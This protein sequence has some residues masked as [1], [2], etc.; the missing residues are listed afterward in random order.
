MNELRIKLTSRND[1]EYD[2]CFAFTLQPTIK[3]ELSPSLNKVVA[4]QQCSRSKREGEV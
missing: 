3:L 1:Y 2:A 4:L